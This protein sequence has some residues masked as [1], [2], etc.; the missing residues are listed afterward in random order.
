MSFEI[1]SR[2][3]RLK[4]MGKWPKWLHA[5]FLLKISLRIG[6]WSYRLWRLWNA[7][8]GGPDS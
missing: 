8:L 7:L 3:Q 2:R 6:V 4:R 1:N 5:P